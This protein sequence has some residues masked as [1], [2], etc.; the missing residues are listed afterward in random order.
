WPA[1][2]PGRPTRRPARGNSEA[3][4]AR[5]PR[6]G[7]RG[8]HGRT[9]RAADAMATGSPMAAGAAAFRVRRKEGIRMSAVLETS[10]R[11]GGGVEAPD[12][13]QPPLEGEISAD[14][15]VVGAG[16]AGLSTALELTARGALVAVLEREFAGFGASGRNAGYLAG[17]Q[18]LEY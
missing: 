2:R 1:C 5:S 13:P 8:G 15:I 3:P 11:L 6:S 14:A 12:D 17:G 16:F 10:R 18:G 7:R 9:R 4:G